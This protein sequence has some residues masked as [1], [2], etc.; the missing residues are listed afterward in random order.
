M[1]ETQILQQLG[2]LKGIQPSPDFANSSKLQ[3]LYQTHQKPS[4]VFM[5]A[6][7]LSA[8]LSIGLV[9][10]FFVF[11]AVLGASNL[12]SPLSPTFEGVNGSLTAEADSV[13]TTIDIH[14]EEMQYVTDIAAQ[15]L[16]KSEQIDKESSLDEEVDSMLNEAINL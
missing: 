7:S 12:R 4:G 8:S 11:I 13:N 14:L 1:K 3:I 10:I 9:I 2:H 6:Q 5:L 15:T 16:A